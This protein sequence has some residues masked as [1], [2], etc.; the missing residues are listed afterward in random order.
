[1]HITWELD[2][3]LDDTLQRGKDDEHT[4][5]RGT[6]YAPYRMKRN[7]MTNDDPPP[8]TNVVTHEC[9]ELREQDTASDY[10]FECRTKTDASTTSKVYLHETQ[11]AC[12]Q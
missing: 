8:Q 9:S 1:M 7:T 3:Y 4:A 6:I 10:F 5:H 11:T 12:L 2:G